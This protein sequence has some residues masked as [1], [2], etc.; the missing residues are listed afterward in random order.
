MKIPFARSANTE[1][2]SA[3]QAPAA[4]G[5]A[6]EAGIT[7]SAPAMLERMERHKSHPPGRPGM[8]STASSAPAAAAHQRRKHCGGTKLS[9]APGTASLISRKVLLS[10]R[11][12][13]H[14]LT[15]LPRCWNDAPRQGLQHA[16]AAVQHEGQASCKAVHF[17]RPQ[18]AN[19]SQVAAASKQA[20]GS[21]H[22]LPA[23]VILRIKRRQLLASLEQ[24]PAVGMWRVAAVHASPSCLQAALA[25]I[26]PG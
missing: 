10:A 6:G 14:F 4:V 13:S 20:A 7:G 15:A 8:R 25:S 16:C 5:I 24:R 26:P 1:R 22:E 12:W 11:A 18:A 19:R 9:A 3:S 2:T 17:V 23:D 21:G